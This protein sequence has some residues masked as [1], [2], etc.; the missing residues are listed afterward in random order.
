MDTAL[1]Y[2]HGRQRVY[3]NNERR[4][5]ARKGNK[6]ITTSHVSLTVHV[7]LVI[8]FVH[9]RQRVRINNGEAEK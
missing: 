6:H 1:L 3:M 8:L 7:Y 9:G 4:G 5:E 2:V